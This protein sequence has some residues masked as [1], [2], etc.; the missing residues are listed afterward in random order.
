MAIATRVTSRLRG[1]AGE[2]YGY[3]LS[4]PYYGVDYLIVSRIDMPAFGLRET[5]IVPAEF[6]YGNVIALVDGDNTLALSIPMELCSHEDALLTV[7]YEMAIAAPVETPVAEFE[8]PEGDS[9]SED[10][11]PPESLSE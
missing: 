10:I 2:A 6:A 8:T 1:K 5:R 3:E 11:A 9:P 4:E 7:G